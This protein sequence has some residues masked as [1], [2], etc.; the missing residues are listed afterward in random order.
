MNIYLKS[1]LDKLAEIKIETSEKPG[2]WANIRAKKKRGEAAAKPGDKDYPD[3][4]QWSDLTKKAYGDQGTYSEDERWLEGGLPWGKTKQQAAKETKRFADEAKAQN[5]NL[6]FN[7]QGYGEGSMTPDEAI[8][9][10]L[11]TKTKEDLMEEEDLPYFYTLSTEEPKP[12]LFN[13]FS[14]RKPLDYDNHPLYKKK[15]GDK[16]DLNEKQYADLTKKAVAAWQRSEGKN[17][18]GGLNA[19]GRASYKRETGG[20]L[21]PPVKDAKA[22][23]ERGKRRKSFCSRMCGMKKKLTSAKTSRDPDSRINK[24]LRAW[25]CNCS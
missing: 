10:I 8:S 16:D 13:F 19:K 6:T 15:P 7:S 22:G 21:K 12:G 24:A 25:S 3:K 9:K 11:K 2:L 23:G 18:K 4:E 1:Y 17:P 20:T 5:L 14:K